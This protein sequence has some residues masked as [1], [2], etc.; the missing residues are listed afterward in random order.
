MHD[1][2]MI[3]MNYVYIDGLVDIVISYEFWKIW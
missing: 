3:W 1:Y 2:G